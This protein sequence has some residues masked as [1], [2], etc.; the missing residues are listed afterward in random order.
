[1]HSRREGVYFCISSLLIG[2]M[3]GVFACAVGEEVLD[4]QCQ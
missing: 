4:A 3:P 1:M 2:K